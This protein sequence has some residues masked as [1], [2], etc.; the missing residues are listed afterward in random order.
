MAVETSADAYLP[1][2]IVLFKLHLEFLWEKL[3]SIFSS[4]SSPP[5]SSAPP[6]TTTTTTNEEHSTIDFNSSWDLYLM[7]AL[8]GL[9][10]ALY[11]MRRQRVAL[12]QQQQQPIRAPVQ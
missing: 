4:S 5:P 12:Q 10:G 2:S 6:P 8:L 7:A 3:S 11:T 1:V 9:I